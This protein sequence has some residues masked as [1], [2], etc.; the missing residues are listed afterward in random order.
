MPLRP[1]R[2]GRP[3]LLGLLCPGLSEGA[4]WRASS[5][6]RA[7]RS[8]ARGAGGPLGPGAPA[9]L[10]SS[11]RASASLRPRPSDPSW[12]AGLG[13]LSQPKKREEREE[14]G[15]CAPNHQRTM[16]ACVPMQRRHA[17]CRHRRGR[18]VQHSFRRWGHRRRCPARCCRRRPPPPRPTRTR[19][20]RP[21]RPGPHRPRPAPAWLSPASPS[22]R[23]K[24]EPP[25]Q[26]PSSEA[27]STPSWRCWIS[28]STSTLTSSCLRPVRLRFLPPPRLPPSWLPSSSWT[29][30]CRWRRTPPPLVLRPP[31]HL[32][33][34]LA[35]VPRLL[36]PRS[37][38]MTR[39]RMC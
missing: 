24:P 22:S 4:P 12:L 21:P 33:L 36:L 38:T 20:R 1:W 14:H 11:G 2:P 39:R 16:S 23:E 37:R 35:L 5:S 19:L 8:P 6:S 27:A 29:S 31:P 28:T 7:A 34:L 30:S 26:R 10:S 3:V 25:Q 15:P 17:S 18:R 32:R 13:A 9:P